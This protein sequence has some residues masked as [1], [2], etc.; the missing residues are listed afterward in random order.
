MIKR[1]WLLG[2]ACLVLTG[3]EPNRGRWL[4]D[5]RQALETA[6]AADKPLFVVFRCEH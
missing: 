2:F 4:T 3:A 5:Y 1:R 6:R